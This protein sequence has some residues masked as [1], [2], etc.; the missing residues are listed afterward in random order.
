NNL[1]VALQLVGRHD[2]ALAEAEQ[3]LALAPNFAEA[4]H[5]R[6]TV[7]RPLGRLDEARQELE[8]AIAL[9]PRKAEFYRSLAE[10][11][12]FTDGDPHCAMIEALARD[13]GSLSDEERIHLHFALGKIYDDLGQHERGFSHLIDG[14]ALKR[15]QIAYDEEAVLARFDV[16]RALFSA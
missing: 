9:A 2:E 14:N 1:G 15:R 6:G 5:G 13:M 8:R 16:T 11:K 4:H 12:H 10:A 3:A 7:L